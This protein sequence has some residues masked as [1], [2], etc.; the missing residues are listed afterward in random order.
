[1]RSVDNNGSSCLEIA[2]TEVGHSHFE[3]ISPRCGH[4]PHVFCSTSLSPALGLKTRRDTG[5]GSVNG[6]SEEQH[7]AKHEQSR[8]GAVYVGGNFKSLDQT[9]KKTQAN[10]TT[11]LTGLGLEAG[12]WEHH[13]NINMP[14]TKRS[15][16]SQYNENDQRTRGWGEFG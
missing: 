14:K 5:F 6:P 2:R 11:R 10:V 16:T 4:Q 8:K 7:D 15:W 13:G 9:I 3:M 12:N 1:V